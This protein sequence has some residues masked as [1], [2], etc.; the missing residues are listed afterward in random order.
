ML[1]ALRSRRQIAPFTF[2]RPSTVAGALALHAEPGTNAF[3]A[4]GIELIDWMKYGHAVDRVIRLDGIP[5]LS[6]ITVGPDGLRI[7]AMATHS[8][9]AASP[10]IHQALPDLAALWPA[11]AN[12]RVRFTGTIGGNVMCG[13]ADYD[14]L[15]AL[16]ALGAI[17]SVIAGEGPADTVMA[18]EGPGDTVMVGEGRPSTSLPGAVP[19]GVDGGPAPAM[20][21]GG[22]LLTR[23]TIPGP[24]SK[25]LYADRSLRPALTLWLG[26]DIVGDGVKALRVAVG[27]AHSEPVCVTR[28]LEGLPMA[29]LGHAAAIIAKD[30][31]ELLPEPVTDGRASASYRRRMVGVLTRRILIRAGDSS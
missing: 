14:G 21:V 27:M 29:D 3:M 9:I 6:E 5:A 15:P 22:G 23:F 20:T 28:P 18:G 13:K 25:R 8:A 26:L 11:V 24:S 10:A 7:G 19:I 4:G 2:H 30:V 16:M 31:A 17:Y 12:P 1:V